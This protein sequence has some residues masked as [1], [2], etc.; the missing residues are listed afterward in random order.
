MR[1][2]T[3]A[4]LDYLETPRNAGNASPSA[5]EAV[6][7][8]QSAPG[9]LPKGG[10]KHTAIVAAAIMAIALASVAAYLYTGHLAHLPATISTTSPTTTTTPATTSTMPPNGS[11]SGTFNPYRVTS[12]Q[13]ALYGLPDSSSY[14]EYSNTLI[15][16]A[17]GAPFSPMAAYGLNFTYFIMGAPSEP[18]LNYNTAIPAKYA[19]ATYPLAVLVELFNF[20]NSTSASA[21]F[22]S[23]LYNNSFNGTMNPARNYSVP[24]YIA[25]NF[26]YIFNISGYA[27][28]S[29]FYRSN[30]GFNRTV[31]EGIPAVAESLSPIYRRLEQYQLSFRYGRY[32][33][34]INTYGVNGTMDSAYVANIAANI[35]R[36]FLNNLQR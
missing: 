29:S 27:N 10:E 4:E 13:Y 17:D 22:Q 34:L 5:G 20:T 12:R 3:M 1:C 9:P 16:N 11:S 33:V 31:V 35:A 6:M 7:A 25:S 2:W 26:T 19:A 30:L 24:I 36:A 32:V 18:P 28:A 21:F 8:Q 23:F 15:V 14:A